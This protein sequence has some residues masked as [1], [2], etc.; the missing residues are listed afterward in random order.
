MGRFLLAVALLCLVALASDKA[1]M[2][3]ILVVLSGVTAWWWAHRKI[4]KHDASRAHSSRDSQQKASAAEPRSPRNEEP[5]VAPV[6]MDLNEQQ[7]AALRSAIA[8]K[9]GPRWVATPEMFAIGPR[10]IRL[11]FCFVG[12]VPSPGSQRVDSGY[13]IDTTQVVDW[14]VAPPNHDVPSYVRYAAFDPAQRA[15][16][17]DWHHHGRCDD[18]IGPQGVQFHLRCIA[19]RI[20]QCGTTLREEEASA[21]LDEL[22]RVTALFG[23]LEGVAAPCARLIGMIHGIMGARSTSADRRTRFSGVGV[24]AADEPVV[25]SRLPTES[26]PQG[27]S[28]SSAIKSQPPRWISHSERIR[29]AERE[30]TLA[31]SYVGTTGL[32]GEDDPATQWTID[33]TRPVLWEGNPHVEIYPYRPAYDG[34]SPVARGAYLRWHDGGRVDPSMPVTYVELFLMGVSAHVGRN[35]GALPSGEAA[36]LARELR[37]LNQLYFRNTPHQSTRCS[38]LLVLLS[39]LD[40]ELPAPTEPEPFVPNRQYW[41]I[42]LGFPIRLGR[43]LKAGEPVSPS[44]ALEWLMV[45]G[46]SFRTPVERAPD[47]FQSLFARRLEREYPRGFVVP[48]PKSR[49]AYRVWCPSGGSDW[50]TVTTQVP[51]YSRLSAP[52]DKLRAVALA[53]TEELEPYS[54]YLG[55]EGTDKA[56]TTEARLLLPE[57]IWPKD[58]VDAIDALASRIGEGMLVMK[59]DEL[60]AA[61]GSSHREHVLSK[62]GWERLSSGLLKRGLALEWAAKGPPTATVASSAIDPRVAVFHFGAVPANPAP[63]RGDRERAFDEATL[64]LQ[65]ALFLVQNDVA[66]GRDGN[67]TLGG[68]DLVRLQRAVM[69]QPSIDANDRRRL[70]ARLRL[71]HEK[72]VTL[73]PLRKAMTALSTASIDR[74]LRMLGDVAHDDG[75]VSPAEI[76]ALRKIYRAFGRNQDD[77]YALLHGAASGLTAAVSDQ[78]A[79]SGVSSVKTL[80]A[81]G[82]NA[83]QLDA[84]RLAALEAETHAVQAMLAQIFVDDAAIDADQLDSAKSTETTTSREQD[85]RPDVSHANR[86]HSPVLAGLDALHDSLARAMLEKREHRR[87]ELI[88]LANSFGL[89]LD[90]ALERI[91]EAAYDTWNA[92][93]AEGEDPLELSPEAIQFR[94]TLAGHL[95]SSSAETSSIAP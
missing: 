31:L 88:N 16:F 32:A 53:S 27:Y 22:K 93:F 60:L 71:R 47:A 51:D 90:G 74:L 42:P 77:V 25:V 26:Q 58:L 48:T 21:L 85:T 40:D 4:F 54:R 62:A 63:D 7:K 95:P 2:I 68:R 38:E 70:I 94:D 20:A 83:F 41:A 35:S 9:S 36:Y 84:A 18:S 11:A 52:L 15:L 14:N 39:A 89:M 46:S 66:A 10:L 81:A 65:L 92:P 43:V 28:I 72:A 64:A 6:A 49:L 17:L 5:E 1:V 45:T 19:S 23:A 80:P 34:L 67:T 87:D 8:T 37:R 76:G 57:S 12:S 69:A 50:R 24:S 61:L 78:S 73:P 55:R 33:P 91:N 30:V 13:V 82:G 3:W 59:M 86:V 56:D 75:E 29:V 79:Q 44:L